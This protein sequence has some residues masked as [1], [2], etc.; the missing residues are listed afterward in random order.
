MKQTRY[1]SSLRLTAILA[2]LSAIG[3]ILGKLLAFN[4]TEFM[5]FSLEN[6]SILLAGILFGPLCGAAVGIVQD[7]VGCLIVGYAIN[8]I[9]TLG[10]AAVGIVSGAV[11]RIIGKETSRLSIVIS[12]AAAHLVGSVFI[13]S[14]GLAI[15]YSLPFGITLAWRALNYAIVGS[16][17]TVILFLLLKSKQLLS[18]TKKGE[19]RQ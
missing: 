16:V 19:S 3:I 18:Y 6:L 13:K 4:L 14:M 17:E 15:F 7:L 8:P 1:T 9:I 5:R 11:S 2:V 12:V 10:C